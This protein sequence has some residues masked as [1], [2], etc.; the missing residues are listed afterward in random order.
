MLGLGSVKKLARFGL[1]SGLSFLIT[2]GLPILLVERASIAPEYAA[3][4]GLITA[5]LVNFVTLRKFVYQSGGD[6]RVQGVR[7]LVFSAIFR[8]SEYLIF[9]ILYRL[10]GVPYVLA[11]GV[12]LAASFIVKYITY[13]RLLFN[14]PQAN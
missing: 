10:L 6:W 14:E 2:M 12:V 7:F 3:A 1:A 8:G 9:L 11:L 4:A 5:F 13:D